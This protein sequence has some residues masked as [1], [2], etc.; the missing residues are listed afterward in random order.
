M[1]SFL[2]RYS[3]TISISHLRR[4]RFL[5]DETKSSQTPYGAQ[6]Q[7]SGTCQK[8]LGPSTFIVQDVCPVN[9]YF[10]SSELTKFPVS[11]AQLS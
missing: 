2:E 5:F 10:Q 8:A 4:A 7:V 1:N 6:K 9:L 11:R 3:K